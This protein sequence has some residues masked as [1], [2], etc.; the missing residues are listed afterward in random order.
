M[1]FFQHEEHKTNLED[2]QWALISPLLPPQK[3]RGKKRADG[4]Q[5]IGDSDGMSCL[6][7]LKEWQEEG[8]I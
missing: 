8:N 2:E 6:G 3:P 1:M 5:T 7:R 4:R